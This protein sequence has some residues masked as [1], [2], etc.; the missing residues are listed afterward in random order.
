[1][2][3]EK[4][5]TRVM[6]GRRPGHPRLLD[7]PNRQDVEARHKAGYEGGPPKQQ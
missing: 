6:A 2:Q 3:G 1:L 5:F 7:L 4:V